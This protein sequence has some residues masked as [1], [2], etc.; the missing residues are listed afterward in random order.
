MTVKIYYRPHPS[1]KYALG[2]DPAEGLPH[3]DPSAACILDAQTLRVCAIIHGRIGVHEF[4]RQISEL[5][6]RYHW[7]LVVVARLNH[8]HAVQ[9]ALTHLRYP[10]IYLHREAGN[11]QAPRRPGFPESQTSK[12]MLVANLQAE[13]QGGM[14]YI[15]D[16]DMIREL[17]EYQNPAPGKYAGPIGGHDDLVVA[18]ELALQGILSTPEL[19]LSESAR[20]RQRQASYY[21]VGV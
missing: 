13:L 20:G 7:A 1:H 2:A 17:V 5:G 11:S 9:E 3:S 6:E 18:L 19:S 4:A 8:G 16:R 12:T 21:P 14:I 15:P 10:K